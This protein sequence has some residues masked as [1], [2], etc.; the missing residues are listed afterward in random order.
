[1]VAKNIMHPPDQIEPPET[2]QVADLRRTVT[3]LEARLA[4]FEGKAQPADYQLLKN[5]AKDSGVPKT[6]LRRW[7]L[8]GLVACHEDKLGM[9]VDVTDARRVRFEQARGP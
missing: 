9:W 2:Q 4:A 5:A 1:M 3:M 7:C 8:A 6:T